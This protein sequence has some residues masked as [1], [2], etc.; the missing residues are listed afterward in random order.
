M[1]LL[2]VDT[3]TKS[4]SLALGENGKIGSSRNIT[5]KKVLSS[6]IIPGIERLLEKEGETPSG[7][8]GFVIG[9]GPGSFTSLRVGLS[10]I[11]ALAF[12]TK[13]PVVGI[14]S[15]DAI[16]AQVKKDGKVCV[17]T[18]ARRSLVYASFYEKKGEA[19]QRKGPYLLATVE[20]VV[21]RIKN[22]VIFTGDGVKLFED[23]IKKLCK[24][25][26]VDFSIEQEKYWLPQA[27]SL[28]ALSW[29]RFKHQ[30]Y[31]DLA[32]LVPLY[33]YP[34]DCQVQK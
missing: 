19:V 25:N 11:K 27:R 18:D 23:H 24:M 31:D 6:S 22:P 9:L 4:F 29:E 21:K 14:S 10:T 26:K 32:A 5:L 28:I 20:E 13:K 33:L 34:E 3:S 16:A 8:D 30:Q 17:L 2:G 12:V 15:L 7:L 1:K